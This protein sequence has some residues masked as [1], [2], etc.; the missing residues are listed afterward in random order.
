MKSTDMELQAIR[1][2]L[3]L[4]QA[5]PQTAEPM[6]SPWSEPRSQAG[7]VPKQAVPK[8]A[9]PKQGVL[10]SNPHQHSAQEIA[11]REDSSQ[12]TQKIAQRGTHHQLVNQPPKPSPQD[13]IDALKQ[14]SLGNDPTASTRIDNLVA[15]EIYRLEAQAITVN[16]RSRQQAADIMALKRAAQQASVG[17][18]RQGIHDHP[19]LAIITQFLENC[20]SA[21]VPYIERNEYGQFALTYDTVDFH[22]AEQEAIATAHALRNRQQSSQPIPLSPGSPLLETALPTEPFTLG[23]SSTNLTT[24]QAADYATEYATDG[25]EHHR[26]KSRYRHAYRT[27]DDWVKAAVVTTVSS[28]NQ[29]LGQLTGQQ[30]HARRRQHRRYPS[31]VTEGF[32]LSLAESDEPE[33]GMLSPTADFS[34]E[35]FRTKVREN[36]G[37]NA[38]SNSSFSWLDGTIWFSGAAI[39]RIVIQSVVANYPMVQTALLVALIG[40]IVFALYRV[41]VSNSNDYGLVYRLCIGILGL[42]SAGLF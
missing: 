22:R 42:F 6:G 27:A 34:V 8:R 5:E 38:Y 41:I 33:E 1:E 3:Q 26:R 7:A 25:D 36:A 15:Q 21:A 28:F 32:D 11:E 18:R 35:R 29:L 37:E 31:L 17:L 23:S 12:G 2:K 10:D 30:T 40:V 24:G 14:R 9:A 19:Q 13:A 39:A 16:E 20:P 4:L